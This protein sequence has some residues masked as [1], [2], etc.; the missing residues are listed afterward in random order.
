MWPYTRLEKILVLVFLSVLY[1]AKL[2]AETIRFALNLSEM[3]VL[4]EIPYAVFGVHFPNRAYT[5]IKKCFWTH[6]G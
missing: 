5:R 2:V 6:Y 4:C 1:G 3:F